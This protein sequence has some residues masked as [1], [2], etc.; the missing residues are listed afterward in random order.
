MKKVD[1]AHPCLLQSSWVSGWTGQ[2]IIHPPP[3]LSNLISCSKS[4]PTF[5]QLFLDM[6]F[7]SYSP[8]NHSFKFSVVDDALSISLCV[9]RQVSQVL[10]RCLPVSWS[11]LERPNGMHRVWRGGRAGRGR[12][13]M[14]WVRAREVRRGGRRL[15]PALLGKL[16]I[17]VDHHSSIY[18]S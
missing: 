4:I 11:L 13:Q 9:P 14:P 8:L 2:S 15:L 7:A 18:F 12:R 6:F 10:L 3:P 16:G 1:T 5:Q 17:L